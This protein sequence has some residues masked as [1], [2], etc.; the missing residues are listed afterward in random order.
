MEGLI[1]GD[2]VVVPFPFSDLSNHK[3]RPALVI[4]DPEGDDILLMQITRKPGKYS[5]YIDKNCFEK[6]HL[7]VQ[8]YV[9]INKLFSADKSI[10]LCRRGTLK[11]VTY[12]SIIKKLIEIIKK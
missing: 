11:K 4:S 12:I 1:K 3:K 8:S 9:K 7:P 6:G 5:H 2:V 10:V